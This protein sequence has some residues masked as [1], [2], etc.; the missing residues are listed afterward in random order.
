MIEIKILEE[1]KEPITYLIKSEQDINVVI[2]DISNAL[3]KV[4]MDKSI[5]DDYKII[6]KPLQQVRVLVKEMNEKRKYLS[7]KTITVYLTSA[8]TVS[9]A[10]KSTVHK[11]NKKKS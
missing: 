6:D 2:R 9:N 4:K 3:S 11:H 10:L 8:K 1:L 7:S 5:L